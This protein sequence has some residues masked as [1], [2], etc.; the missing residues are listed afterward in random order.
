MTEKI[1]I[2]R[3][4]I[5]LTI[6][7]VR[8]E[9][10]KGIVEKN[11]QF[12]AFYKNSPPNEIIFGEQFKDKNG[13]N[14]VFPSIEIAREYALATLK[15][16]IYPPDY[17]HPLHYKKENLDEIMNKKLKFDIGSANN[18]IVNDTIEGVLTFCTLAAN[19]PHLPATATII[20]AE[21]QE[22]KFNFFEIKS[23][24]IN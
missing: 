9:T 7:N 5:Y 24:R 20:T 4:E 11:D 19:P 8:F 22:K 15:K 3:N 13:K 12:I 2:N 23:I 18:E 1:L 10:E 21:G 17:L 16:A 6:D 14:V